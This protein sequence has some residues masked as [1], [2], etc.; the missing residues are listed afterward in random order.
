VAQLRDV[1]Q[2]RAVTYRIEL[3]Q[4]GRVVESA[5]WPDLIGAKQRAA[6]LML[7]KRATGAV[8]VQRLTGEVEARY[9]MTEAA[10][11][12]NDVG[13]TPDESDP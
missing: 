5:T 7:V 9:G 8:I 13:T 6:Y 11:E 1:V 2:G 3:F 10:S 12:P 4:E